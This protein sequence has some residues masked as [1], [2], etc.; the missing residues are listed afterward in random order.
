MSD[1]GRAIP[2]N[3]PNWDRLTRVAQCAKSDPARWLAMED[4]YGATGRDPRMVEA[5]AIALDALW[6]RG[7]TAVLTD[8]LG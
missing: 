3:D 7:T 2:A 4:I 8:F 6:S 1:A 5:F